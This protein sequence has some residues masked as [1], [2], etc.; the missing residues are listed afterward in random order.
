MTYSLGEKDRPEQAA[1]NLFSGLRYL[2][3][4]KADIIIVD[5]SFYPDGIGKAVFNRVRKAAD[6]IIKV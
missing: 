1:K 6:M 2:D 4:R 5:G 3:E